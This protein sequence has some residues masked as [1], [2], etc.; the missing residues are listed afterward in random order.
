[1][2]VSSQVSVELFIGTR[3]SETSSASVT[4]VN[5][6]IQIDVEGDVRKEPFSQLLLAAGGRGLLLFAAAAAGAAGAAGARRP[7]R[8]CAAV[9]LPPLTKLE[10]SA[11]A[12]EALKIESPRIALKFS[13]PRSYMS[14]IPLSAESES[15]RPS[16]F[17]FPFAAC[18]C[19]CRRKQARQGTSSG[20]CRR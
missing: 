8:S 20:T 3:G 7:A 16:P 17:A 19:C 15:P 4:W 2:A 13:A 6:K 14:L 10:E 11:Q 5:R 12:E 9:A 18:A 1:M